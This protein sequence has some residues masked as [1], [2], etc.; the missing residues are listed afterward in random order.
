MALHVVNIE[1]KKFVTGLFWQALPNQKDTT[2]EIKQLASKLDFDFAVTRKQSIVQVGFASK[3]DGAE[4]GMLSLAATVSKGEE[5][6]RNWLG[7]FELPDG[8]FFYIAIIDGTFLPH[9]DIAG[10]RDEILHKMQQ[11]VGISDDWDKIYAPED[12]YIENSTF[13]TI[14]DLLPRTSSGKLETH[15]WWMLQP[16]EAGMPWGMLAYAAVFGLVATAGYA[17]WHKLQVEKEEAL[18]AQRMALVRQAMFKNLAQQSAIK[19]P[20]PWAAMPTADNMIDG[21]VNALSQNMLNA[22]GWTLDKFSCTLAGGEY[23]WFR[24]VT[25]ASMLKQTIPDVVIDL[26]GV[27][28]S[29]TKPLDFG[30]SQKE[31]EKLS[32]S[33][34]VVNLLSKFQLR[35]ID[36][37]VSESVAPPPPPPK[38]GEPLPPVPDWRTYKFQ[39]IS[40]VSPAAMKDILISPGIRITHVTYTKKWQVEG[41]YYVMP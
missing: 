6:L 22:G 34:S 5:G 40:S 7:A 28:G 1:G 20:H 11:D 2:G 23:T 38:P 3:E 30:S 39:Y 15:K 9:G 29:L 35:G 4:K 37:K 24:N 17:Y 32:P 12:F 21:C 25:T 33:D 16:V 10:T 18:K 41:D 36:L 31:D 14:D 19:M 8:Q 26:T 27:K 13:K